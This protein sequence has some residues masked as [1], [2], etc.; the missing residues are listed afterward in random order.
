MHPISVQVVEFWI[1]DHE[2]LLKKRGEM[3]HLGHMLPP[4]SQIILLQDCRETWWEVL[5]SHRSNNLPMQNAT[6]NLDGNFLGK[7]PCGKFQ[8]VSF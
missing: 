4:Q 5:A 2:G 1:R 8:G 3:I 6:S 7:L